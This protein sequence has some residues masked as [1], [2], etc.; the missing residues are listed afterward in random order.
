MRQFGSWQLIDPPVQK[1]YNRD[2]RSSDK[3]VNYAKQMRMFSDLW[4]DHTTVIIC[5]E[6]TKDNVY[7][8]EYFQWYHRIS[9][10]RV[11]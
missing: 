5:S 11:G 7:L 10:L 6:L 9:R 1:Q 3:G 4:N 2:E 8:E